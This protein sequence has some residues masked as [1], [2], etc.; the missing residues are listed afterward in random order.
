MCFCVCPKETNHLPSQQGK[1]LLCLIFQ[2]QATT[3]PIPG[4]HPP[5]HPSKVSRRM[6]PGWMAGRES[7][8]CLHQ[9]QS[10]VQ[11]GCDFWALRLG[12]PEKEWM[13][14]SLAI[15]AS[16]TALT[17]ALEFEEHLVVFAL[18]CQMPRSSSTMEGKTDPERRLT[19]D[20]SRPWGY[21]WLSSACSALFCAPC[22]PGS[23]GTVLKLHIEIEE[24]K[25]TKPHAR[26]QP[27]PLAPVVWSSI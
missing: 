26:S 9:G 12:S 21:L 2:P 20:H 7:Q 4:T 8:G 5:F 13:K 25:S 24:A 27:A 1:C 6:A 17:F 19:Q 22:I 14:G 23:I 15:P 16:V 18:K 3:C 10:L 11:A